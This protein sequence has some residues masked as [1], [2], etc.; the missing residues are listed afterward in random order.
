MKAHVMPCKKTKSVVQ[1]NLNTCSLTLLH[2]ILDLS[3]PSQ[4]NTLTLVCMS[5]THQEMAR[6]LDS[7]PPPTQLTHPTRS[8][9]TWLSC[10]MP[11]SPNSTRFSSI[12]HNKQLVCL[13]FQKTI[14]SHSDSPVPS[15]LLLF[16]FMVTSLFLI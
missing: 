2:L 5:Q 3:I 4:Q 1:Y 8:R 11:I 16:P 10:S 12:P 13:V 14:I 15:C 6:I 9:P 7:F